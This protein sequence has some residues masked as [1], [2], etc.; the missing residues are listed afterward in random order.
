MRNFLG[1][2][3]PRTASITRLPLRT[4]W[5]SN[6]CPHLSPYVHI[7]P[8]V[9]ARPRR[10][11]C[12]RRPPIRPASQSPGALLCLPFRP[13][14]SPVHSRAPI[15][16]MRITCRILR[17]AWFEQVC[18]PW[19]A[20][21]TLDYP[22]NG[23]AGLV[24]TPCMPIA[25]TAKHCGILRRGCFI[26]SPSRRR[27]LGHP[28]V[29]LAVRCFSPLPA[30]TRRGSGSPPLAGRGRGRGIPCAQTRPGSIVCQNSVPGRDTHH[31]TRNQ[32]WS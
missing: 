18:R 16:S 1:D 3:G 32:S 13:T 27:Y 26:R 4:E 11:C 21:H 25:S 6:P 15:S 9:I 8:L 22:R 23:I 2:F 30:T 24:S 10:L 29:C 31:T 17:H 12:G 19:H 28:V 7:R 5:C 14:R 20:P